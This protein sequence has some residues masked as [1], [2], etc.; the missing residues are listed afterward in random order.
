[1]TVRTL[2]QWG[3]IRVEA[4][5]PAYNPPGRVP[6]W[7]MRDGW[8]LGYFGYGQDEADACKRA[9]GEWMSCAA[10]RAGTLRTE[11]GSEDAIQDADHEYHTA[12]QCYED[13]A[14]EHGLQAYATPELFD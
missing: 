8:I 12:K 1:M 4:G 14:K 3:L 11:H 10:G 5:D 13:F 6:A 7:V 9:L 2:K